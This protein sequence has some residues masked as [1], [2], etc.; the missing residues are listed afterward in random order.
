[1]RAPSEY[2]EVKTE[3]T[4]II[5]DVK[6]SMED[7]F[8]KHESMS[9]IRSGE[10]TAVSTMFAFSVV[11]GAAS[12]TRLGAKAEA[13]AARLK[14]TMED[15]ILPLTLC[16]YTCCLTNAREFESKGRPLTRSLKHVSPGGDVRDGDFGKYMVATG[17][18]QF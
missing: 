12:N 4:G 1:M 8:L 15:N 3:I 16:C 2:D 14:T 6:N 18:V 9:M 11:R 5:A 10:R 13:D 17:R 7:N